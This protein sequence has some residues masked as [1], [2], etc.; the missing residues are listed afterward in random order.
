M[1]WLHS[2]LTAYCLIQTLTPQH[3]KKKKKETL[4]PSLFPTDE[5]ESPAL[6][7]Q[8]HKSNIHYK[9]YFAKQ[10]LKFK[11]GFIILGRTTHSYEHHVWETDSVSIWILKRTGKTPE[12]LHQGIYTCRTCH[13]VWRIEAQT[14][15]QYNKYHI[16][17]S[18]AIYCSSFVALTPAPEKADYLGFHLS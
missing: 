4:L 7:L 13:R 1:Q 18:T 9:D 8:C 2:P 10:A 15:L 11:P 14:S 17:Q 3:K 6:Y 12:C 5:K 16:I